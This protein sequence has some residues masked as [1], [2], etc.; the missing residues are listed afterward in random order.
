[1]KTRSK[2]R[3]LETNGTDILQKREL[4]QIIVI[5]MEKL[6]GMKMKTLTLTIEPTSQTPI[7]PQKPRRSSGLLMKT[8][9]W[10]KVCP[11][12]LHLKTQ[13]FWTHTRSSPL[14]LKIHI[15]I[16]LTPFL[17]SSLKVIKFSNHFP[18]LSLRDVNQNPWPEKLKN[19]KN[20]NLIWIG[21][22]KNKKN[23][24]KKMRNSIQNY[25]EV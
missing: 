3:E 5:S 19:L 17:F 1:M 4:F 8:S 24:I 9:N 7:H 15:R 10:E 16:Y 20:W 25:K 13:L 6:N 23:R 18:V 11:N 2:I 21:C 22:S 14:T 12:N